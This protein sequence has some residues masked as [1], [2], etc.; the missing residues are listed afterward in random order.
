MYS[1]IGAY[2]GLA[3]LGFFFAIIFVAHVVVMTFGK[4]HI[5]R[6]ALYKWDAMLFVASITLPIVATTFLVIF[7]FVSNM[8]GSR[9]RPDVGITL[10]VSLIAGV[11]SP[12]LFTASMFA[13]FAALLPSSKRVEVARRGSMSV[14]TPSEPQPPKIHP[15]DRPD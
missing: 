12:L 1:E 2:L 10:F 13:T 6:P 5:E 8:S 7:G 11:S 3:S 14:D 15:L 9:S 4:K